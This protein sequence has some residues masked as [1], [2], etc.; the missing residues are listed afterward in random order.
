M[1]YFHPHNSVLIRS[2][3]N[4]SSILILVLSVV[5]LY[6]MEIS[7]FTE[8]ITLNNHFW[9]SSQTRK[10]T[11]E[12]LRAFNNTSFLFYQNL[13][14]TCLSP[15]LYFSKRE[16]KFSHFLFYCSDTFNHT[17]IMKTI[18]KTLI[19]PNSMTYFGNFLVIDEL[20]KC[21]FLT[22]HCVINFLS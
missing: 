9:F 19:S 15:G 8:M 6:H 20:D 4:W 2:N 11:F 22:Y 16:N 10:Y 5:F 1:T 12:F 7:K 14:K 3:F 21:F 18:V 17:L 13:E